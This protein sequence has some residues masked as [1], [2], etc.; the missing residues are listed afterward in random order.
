MYYRSNSINDYVYVLKLCFCVPGLHGGWRLRARIRYEQRGVHQTTGMET[1]R[2][3][4]ESW[5]LLKDD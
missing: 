2:L 3:E 5:C 4:K 1:T